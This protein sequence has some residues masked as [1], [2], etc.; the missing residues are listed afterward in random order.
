MNGF[1]KININE[2]IY[3]RD[4]EQTALGR[5]II[6][7]SIVMIDELGFEHFTFKKLARDIES[8]E[9]SIYRYFESKQKLLAYIL[10]WYWVWMDYQILYKT[11][12]IKSPRERLKIIINILSQAQLDNPDT[13]I[14]E[15]ALHRIVVAESSKAYL[16][17]EVDEDNKYGFYREYKR[18]CKKIAEV[19]LELNPT[20]KY[21]HSLVS[22]LIETSHKQAFFAAH[23]PSL[24][25]I[26]IQENNYVELEKYLEYI[27]F[28]AI[29]YS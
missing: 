23:L 3:I 10:S 14:D 22:T 9:A 1:L 12:N 24:T 29:E 25:D 4:P 11:N 16:T 26:T 7:H 20:F 13:E 5:R 28:S 17:K 21:A 6:A 27:L 2:K 15:A 8:T 19:V 18:L